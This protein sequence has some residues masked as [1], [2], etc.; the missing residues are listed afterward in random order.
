MPKSIDLTG[1]RF[2]RLTVVSKEKSGKGRSRWRCVCDCGNE[3]YVLGYNLTSGATKSC[4]CLHR[5]GLVEIGHKNKRHGDSRS[6]LYSIWNGMRQRCR[7]DD[8]YHVGTYKNRGISV[9]QEWNTDYL[10]FK[11]WA[12]SNGYA[13]GLTI[14]RIDNEQ[15]YCPENCRWATPLQ[16]ANNKRNN[17]LQTYNGETH[18]L[19]EWER[20]IGLNRGTLTGRLCAGWTFEKA[21]IPPKKQKSK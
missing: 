16:Q 6:R 7:G 11:K 20:L 15:G 17:R 13:P 2:G 18:T 5:E 4:G 1:Q 19:A 9:C 10:A 21:I 3:K 12:L 8:P 14:D